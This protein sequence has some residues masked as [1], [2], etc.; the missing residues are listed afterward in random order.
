MA[1]T[2]LNIK[3]GFKFIFWG[4]ISSPS[5]SHKWTNF[6]FLKFHYILFIKNQN[7]EMCIDIKCPRKGTFQRF[8]F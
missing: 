2:L 5:S 1:F 6:S 4:E 8:D 7:V 3:D